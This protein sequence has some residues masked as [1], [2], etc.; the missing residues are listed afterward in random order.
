[1]CWRAADRGDNGTM[2]MFWIAA[3][4]AAAVAL[5]GCG[6]GESKAEAPKELKSVTGPAVAPDLVNGGTITGRVAFGGPKPTIRNLDMSAVPYC[7][8]AHPDGAPSEEVVLNANGTLKNAFVWVKSG[9]PDAN[10]QVPETVET[11]D[12]KGCM[13]TPHLMAVM[14]GQKISIQNSDGTNHNIHPMPAANQEWNESEPPGAPAKTQ[15]FPREEIL[16]PIKC[17]IH[18]WMRA[19]I[20]VVSHPFFAVTG[21]E[22]TFTIKGLPPGIYTVEVAHEKY[23]KQEQQVTVGAKESKTADFT[24]KG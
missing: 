23:G 18:S 22:G 12:Q 24:I 21:D 15:S 10:W 11:L 3:A 7:M 6:G 20:S 1:P 4:T 14:T 5:A 8:R 19:Y 17:N 16:L 9:L 13:Y 2:K